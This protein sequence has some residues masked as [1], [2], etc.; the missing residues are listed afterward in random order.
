M[1]DKVIF[2]DTGVNPA[3]EAINTLKDGGVLNPYINE[4]ID[5]YKLGIQAKLK[6]GI[7]TIH[8]DEI[9]SRIATLYEKI[10]KVVDWKEENVLRRSAILRILKRSFISKI[11]EINLVNKT[12]DVNQIA[13]SLTLELI[14]GGHLPNDEIPTKK[15]T[16]VSSILAKYLFV[17]E[18]APFRQSSQSFILKKKVNF[19][20]WLLE[21][22]ACEIE[23]V[24][25]QPFKENA[26]IKAMTL[27]MSE[28]IRLIPEEALSL[29]K[30]KTLVYIAVCRTLFDLDDAFISYH[31]LTHYY[32]EWGKPSGQFLADITQ[33]IFKVSES[34]SSDL[35][36]PLSSDFFNLCERIDT[37][38]TLMG[39]L[40]DNFKNSTDKITETITNKE[41]FKELL[42]QFYDKRIKTLKKRLFR[43]AIFSTLSVFM[44]NWATF[45]LLEVPIANFFF[46]GFNLMAAIADFMVPSIFMF[47][48]VSMIKPPPASNLAVALKTTFQFVFNDEEIELYEIKLRRKKH[49]ISSF[50]I[51][52]L[53]LIGMTISFGAIAWIF[54]IA[55][56]PITSVI[57]DTMTISLNVF[58]AIVIRNKSREL[59]I[60]EKPSPAEFLLDYLSLPIAQVGNFLGN[61]WKEYNVFT[62]FFNYILELPFLSFVEFV[63]TWSQFLKQRKADIH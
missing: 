40:L 50:I 44:S 47:V 18:N 63:E 4:L 56:I 15:I 55:K 6:G 3:R 59:S 17:L 7:A 34:I 8:V 33:N 9:A 48:L 53:Y 39:D 29:E 49:P 11:S 62:V 37:V 10:R 43:L 23:D 36:H 58:A 57:F 35:K 12:S 45:L 61:K 31:M 52:I 60:Q 26:L 21:I 41:K 51:V 42:T 22:A 25:A 19:Y 28:R 32:P 46:E 5:S 13:E 2:T 27:I 24:L 54:Y 30:K 1:A 38:F 20:D 16:V 14:R